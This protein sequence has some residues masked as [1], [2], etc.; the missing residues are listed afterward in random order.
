MNNRQNRRIHLPTLGET[1]FLFLLI[2]QVAFLIVTTFGLGNRAID[3]D[4]GR[5][6]QHM[7]AIWESG[8][9][10][11]PEWIYPTT[12][13]LDCSLL[14]ALPFYG[15]TKDAVTAFACSCVVIIFLWIRMACCLAGRINRYCSL[16]IPA[17]LVCILILIPYSTAN[18]YYWNMM[19]LNGAQ[20]A[21]K[22][23]IPLLLI[24]LLLEPN[25]KAPFPWFYFSSCPLSGRVVLDLSFQRYLCRRSR[26]RTCSGRL[27]H[28]LAVP[29]NISHA[30]FS[31]LHSWQ[32]DY[33]I[34][35]FVYCPPGENSNHRRPNAV[36][37]LSNSGRK[38]C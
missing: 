26:D 8:T 4:T 19:F 9:L 35:G 29:K 7:E 14:L 22:V 21:F 5:L 2:V 25:P 1:L 18:L 38:H 12:M 32:C 31:G 11:V 10:F 20:Y 3:G 13:E 28:P 6:Y 34:V 37:F 33:R 36:Q 24:C 17:P 16:H 30:I 23:M 27:F 15:I